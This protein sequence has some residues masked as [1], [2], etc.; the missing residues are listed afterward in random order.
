VQHAARP[1]V[2][3]EVGVFRCFRIV[4]VFRFFL[5]IKMI[6]VAEEL[7]EAVHR[8]QE[9]VAVAEVVLAELAADVTLRL[10]QFGDRRVFRLESEFRSRQADLGQP[11]TN[12]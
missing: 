10:E 4:L 3:L 2:F 1:E 9:L 5:G 6:E 7:V 11:G 12:R 8:R